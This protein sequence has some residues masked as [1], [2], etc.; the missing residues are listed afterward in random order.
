MKGLKTVAGL[1]GA[2][3]GWLEPPAG[4]GGK[5]VTVV[6]LQRGNMGT[7]AAAGRIFKQLR[8]DA[9]FF[10]GV[11][12]AIKDVG[13]LDVVAGRT[14]VAYSPVKEDVT[15]QTRRKTLDA[16]R[17]LCDVAVGVTHDDRWRRRLPRAM[18][19]LRP[20]ALVD[21]I[22]SGDALIKNLDSQTMQMVRAY[23]GDCVAYD[24]ESW[25][26]MSAAHGAAI[27][28]LVIRGM[29][30]SGVDK[31]GLD[32]SGG[33]GRAAASAAGFLIELISRL[34]SDL[35]RSGGQGSLGSAETP[36]DEPAWPESVLVQL[37]ELQAQDE[38]SASL[39]VKAIAASVRPGDRSIRRLIDSPS[40]WLSKAPASIW[41]MLSDLAAAYDLAMPAV[42]AL[43]TA[44]DKGLM[45]PARW[46]ATAAFYA[47]D[48]DAPLA[49]ELLERA[50]KADQDPFVEVIAMFRE[51]DYQGVLENAARTKV[52]AANDKILVQ[53]LV[54]ESRLQLGDWETASIV[55]RKLLAEFPD[56]SG[57]WISMGGLLRRRADASSATRD[58]DI[59]DA[60]E[61]FLKARDLRRAWTGDSSM[62]V[63]M[64]ASAQID[65]GQLE[66]ALR[67]TRAGPEGATEWEA[68]QQPVIEMSARALLMLDRLDEATAQVERLENG[69]TRATYQGL[70]AKRYGGPKDG[71]LQAFNAALSAATSV[72]QRFSALYHLATLGQDISVGE[73]ELRNEDSELADKVRAAWHSARGEHDAAIRI[74][75]PLEGYSLAGAE[76]LAHA[77]LVADQPVDSARVLENAANRFDA[78]NLLVEAID[79]LG[80]R[81][82][83]DVRRVAKDALAKAR[84]GSDMGMEVLRRLLDLEG[85]E[86]N[87]EEVVSLAQTLLPQLPPD[88]PSTE[89]VRWALIVG[90]LHRSDRKGAARVMETPSLLEPRDEYQAHIQIEILSKERK[91]AET[92]SRLVELA[93]RFA[94]SESVQAAALQG[95]YTMGSTEPLE[96]HRLARLHAETESFFNE[97]ADSEFMQKIEIPDDPREIL[98]RLGDM[99]PEV[100]QQLVELEDMVSLGEM[101]VGL[102]ATRLHKPYMLT[103]IAKGGMLTAFD[104]LS[105]AAEEEIARRALGGELAVDGSTAYLGAIADGWWQA[106]LSS[107]SKVYIADRTVRDMLAT[108][109]DLALR[110][111]LSVVRDHAGEVTLQE[112]PAEISEGHAKRS[113]RALSLALGLRQVPVK[114]L[115]Y[116]EGFDIEWAGAWLGSLEVA[117]D[118]GHPLLCDDVALRGLAASIGVNT[119]SS[120]ALLRVMLERSEV[121]ASQSERFI[122]S[123]MR[124]AVADLPF[125]R[126]RFT[127]L[128]KEDEYRNGPAM[129]AFRRRRVWLDPQ[130]ALAFFDAAIEAAPA[131][132]A[133]VRA[134]WLRAVLS[135]APHVAQ[136]KKLAFVL[137]MLMRTWQA[138]RLNSND[139]PNL[140]A[141]TDV[142]E[143]GFSR[144]EII[145]GVVGELQDLLASVGDPSHRAAYILDLFAH[146]S[147][148]DRG[149]AFKSMLR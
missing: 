97:H 88:D 113:A 132:Q 41:F 55:I 111:S 19:G 39:L 123:W 73:A 125:S 24:M 57:L 131:D 9:A 67:L 139:L 49:G 1:P 6:E 17:H 34:G 8:V 53:S 127:R 114:A 136:S 70:L 120:L 118:K 33:Q 90:L 66:A 135:G 83:A 25:G 128:G 102:L 93:E 3:T 4:D 61:H 141:A 77:H 52:G 43:V 64:A 100:D 12:M 51:N 95:I 28:A 92:A 44:V 2:K 81:H 76:A 72:Q 98:A 116:A 112:T 134:G 148:D 50:R 107:F 109:D 96:P 138:G 89:R 30:D 79:T 122:E 117:V 115:A 14:V 45:P 105:L 60:V 35:G 62:P 21:A 104:P 99:L 146:A 31:D 58:S 23:A 22:T 149:T 130:E 42:R 47:R 108:R 145:D 106:V 16:D 140:L 20:K 126:E 91:G 87:W 121:T 124:A 74:L 110:S 85:R 48:L 7:A 71:A 36:P 63:A 10:S 54:A 103:L 27:P 56:R 133:P 15:Q 65:R 29:S 38:R 26:F 147:P 94:E 129:W 86:G 82:P 46:L 59:L 13:H 5:R 18:A 68:S 69:H 40:A 75:R 80:L 101:P 84:P 137:E 143:V 11:G 144:A 37:R 78:P 32:Q 142:S 119:F